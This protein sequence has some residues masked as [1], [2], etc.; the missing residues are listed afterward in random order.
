MHIRF[1]P[2]DTLI[3]CYNILELVNY[4]TL[5]EDYGHKQ[6]MW[7]WRLVLTQ[8]YNLCN[9][10]HDLNIFALLPSSRQLFCYTS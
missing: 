8:G 9:V 7:G 3:L 4:E 1:Y 2:S 6:N 5:E 10:Y